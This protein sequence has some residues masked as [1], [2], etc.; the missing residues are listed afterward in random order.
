MYVWHCECQ[1]KDC[2]RWLVN[3][4]DYINTYDVHIKRF[5]L[6]QGRIC[7]AAK[8]FFIT[9]CFLLRFLRSE[10]ITEINLFLRI[11]SNVVSQSRK[12]V[13]K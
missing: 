6:G 7:S 4:S 5:E 12:S 2:H 1:Y 10:K 11:I 8:D 9:S 13:K 3:P